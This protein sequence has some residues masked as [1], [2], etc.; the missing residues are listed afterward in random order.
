MGTQQFRIF[1]KEGKDSDKYLWRKPRY[2]KEIIRSSPVYDSGARF[3][4]L[5]LIK[6]KTSV[7][8][9]SG[10]VLKAFDTFDGEHLFGGN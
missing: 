7:R 4:D 2:W 3:P 9:A 6:V 1:G 8:V 5:V 10:D